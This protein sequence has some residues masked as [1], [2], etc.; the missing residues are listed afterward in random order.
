VLLI[1]ERA[2]SFSLLHLDLVKYCEVANTTSI[3]INK[4]YFLSK[5]SNK[6]KFDQNF[7][8][9]NIHNI[10]SILLDTSRIIFSYDIYIIF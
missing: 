4:V 3:L 1:R 2:T 6:V 8:I 10:R 5:K 7:K 9:T